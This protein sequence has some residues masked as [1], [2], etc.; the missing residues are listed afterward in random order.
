MENF[1]LLDQAERNF[2]PLDNPI[3]DI[4]SNVCDE[5]I[6][7][8]F[9]SSYRLAYRIPNGSKISGMVVWNADDED[10]YDGEISELLFLP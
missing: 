2:L 4:N 7:P 1:V 6:S 5:G 10:D 9:K 3:L 8:G